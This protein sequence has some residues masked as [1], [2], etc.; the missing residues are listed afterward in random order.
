[1][2]M[3]SD[4]KMNHLVIKSVNGMA[5]KF[6]FVC[7]HV[8]VCSQTAVIIK[9]WLNVPMII[10]SVALSRTYAGSLILFTNRSSLQIG[11]SL[12]VRIQVLEAIFRET[13]ISPT[14]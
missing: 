7:L 14:S 9:D 4:L 8:R 6:L 11:N 1:M 12:F 2:S 10:G 5:L 13:F 3:L